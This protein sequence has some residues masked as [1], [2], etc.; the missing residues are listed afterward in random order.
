MKKYVF[1]SLLAL[2][3]MVF[4]ACDDMTTPRHK[5]TIDLVANLSSWNF[6][7]NTGQYFCHFDVADL[8]AN[9]Y[10]YG[11]ISISHEYNSGTPKAYQ[12]PLPETT[13]LVQN[14]DDG[15]GGTVPYY[16]Q[17]HIDYVVGIGY[18]E[19]FLTISDYY[20]EYSPDAMVFRMQMT[21]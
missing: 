16:Y 17:E 14:L 13:Y 12:V 19:I 1:V 11:E 4:T 8:T 3:A 20:Y 10:N 5:K 7:S 21:Y 18:V 9:V 6:D 15:Q 2:V